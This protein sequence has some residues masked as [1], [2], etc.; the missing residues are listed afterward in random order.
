MQTIDRYI[1]GPMKAVDGWFTWL[2]ATIT[3]AILDHQAA[4][5]IRGCLGE[6]GVHHGRS[7]LPLAMALRPDERA[8]AIDLFGDQ[9]RNE[10]RSGLGDEAVFRRNL[11][12]HGI[13]AAR[14]EIIQGS[15]LDLTWP[16]VQA[17]TGAAARLF[18][19]DGGHTAP[20][21]QHDLGLALDGLAPAGVIVA[22][23]VFNPEFPGVSQ[24]FAQFMA[25]RPGEVVPFA[26]GDGRMFLCRPD[27]AAGYA[28]CLAAAASHRCLV[29]T[30]P[31]WGGA[32]AVH[33]TPRHLIDHV[34][35]SALSRALTR[36]K[37]GQ[38]L[39]PIVRRFLPG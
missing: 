10:D 34:R 24:G 32:L 1:S 11:A 20:I 22:D 17:R 23:D 38:S 2:D 12:R 25:A 28:A 5:D 29:R 13:D 4:H 3:A 35:R 30:A 16:A 6:I 39:K 31:L 21:V 19:V 18:S 15:S 7:F 9:H 27:D 37:L 26:L 36:H 14:I 33:R 8:F